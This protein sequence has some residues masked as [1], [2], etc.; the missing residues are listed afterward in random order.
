MYEV[1]VVAAKALWRVLLLATRADAL[2][3][4]WSGWTLPRL[5]V[6]TYDAPRD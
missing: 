6:P 2:L 5:R 3:G 1:V 4:S